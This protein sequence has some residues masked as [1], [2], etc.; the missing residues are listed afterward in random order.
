[1]GTCNICPIS[2]ACK[3]NSK[4]DINVQKLYVKNVYFLIQDTI[5]QPRFSLFYCYLYQLIGFIIAYMMLYSML[6][7]VIV[8]GYLVILTILLKG[9]RQLTPQPL[10][11]SVHNHN[12]RM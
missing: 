11:S 7:L 5:P 3:Y 12:I 1:M 8:I 2:Q 6:Y 4:R 9:A 10:V